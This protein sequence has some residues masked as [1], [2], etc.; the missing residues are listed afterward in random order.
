MCSVVA[1]IGAGL[2]LFQG[3]ASYQA[4]QDQI[5]AQKRQVQA[6]A[7]SQASMYKAQAAAAEHNAQM[8]A[9]KQEQIADAYGEEQRRLRSRQRLAEGRLR[10]QTG[11]AGL[12]MAGSSM[13]ILASGQEAYWDDQMTL[14]TNQRN[15]NYNSRVTQSNYLTEGKNNLAAAANVQEDAR[16]QINA[17]D[18]QSSALKWTSILGT[19]S[20]IA[21]PFLTG[22]GSSGGSSSGG[23]TNFGTLSAKAGN[24]YS[25]NY[26]TA[27][28][29]SSITGGWKLGQSSYKNY[30][31]LG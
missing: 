27:T 24:G 7:D 1:A 18:R 25:W 16:R 10:A 13:D 12:D 28:G 20:S 11:A 17:L 23:K 19:A 5:E 26:N 2:S 9:K 30:F 29:A 4:Q 22:G 15:D 8:E 21:A 3:Y 31:T 14:L 6:N